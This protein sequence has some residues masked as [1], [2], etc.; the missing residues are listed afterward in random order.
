MASGRLAAAVVPSGRTQLVYTNS[1]GGA[2][3]ATI[4]TK[5]LS[6]TTDAKVS[7]AI[8]SATVSPELTTQIDT[9]SRNFETTPIVFFNS[10]A[11][12]VDGSMTMQNSTA[13]ANIVDGGSAST[14]NGLYTTAAYLIPNV[15]GGAKDFNP[16][17]RHIPF[18]NNNTIYSVNASTYAA[19]YPNH[20]KVQFNNNTP[21]SYTTNQNLNYTGE[22]F[23]CDPYTH[24][25]PFWSLNS[26]R[27]QGWG[28][29]SNDNGGI[30][31]SQ[32]STSSWYY[33]NVGGSSQQSFYRTIL[34][35][36]GGVL[37]MGS[38]SSG[39]VSF[40]IYK[41]WTPSLS[42]NY[43]KPDNNTGNGYAL[44]ISFTS[45]NSNFDGS[46]LKWVDYNPHADKVYACFWEDDGGGFVM[47]EMDGPKLEA[48]FTSHQ[49][50]AQTTSYSS[51]AAASSGLGDLNPFTDITHLMPS[52]WD[53]T[54]NNWRMSPTW[55]VGDKLWY[56][57]E[58]SSENPLSA[59]NHGWITSDF[60][61]W[62]EV[63]GTSYYNLQI[64]SNTLILSDA[65][66]T[67]KR[68]GNFEAVAQSGR[69]ETDTTFSEIERTGLVLSNNDKL[70]VKN[71]GTVD[72]NI[73]VMGFEEGS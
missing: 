73:Q 58:G 23:T 9:T 44:R 1:S 65:D 20:W 37:G 50:T 28:Y 70:Y 22:A 11:T 6:T 21:A 12:A 15:T 24:S 43:I 66:S 57:N 59:N 5:S 4:L 41:G 61:T 71:N 47:M 53:R 49:A 26:N 38:T 39:T 69:L 68:V 36:R 25:N 67:D 14:V 46:S 2:V 17:G 51:I 60:R 13:F 72:V 34:M 29:I 54:N 42:N 27:Y 48:L 10:A 63:T 52:G 64:D 3:S 8:D 56:V 32:E 33:Q 55:R 35:A 31:E 45:N 62:T 19:D 16:S 40:H 7:M 18:L 30:Y